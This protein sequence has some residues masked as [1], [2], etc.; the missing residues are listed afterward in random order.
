MSSPKHLDEA[1]GVLCTHDALQPQVG[2][3]LPVLAYLGL[4]LTD[5]FLQHCGSVKTYTHVHNYEH[6]QIPMVTDLLM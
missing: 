6:G 1:V 4:H 2:Y 3:L 5:W